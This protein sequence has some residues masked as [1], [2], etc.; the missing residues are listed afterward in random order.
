MKPLFQGILFVAIGLA[1][2]ALIALAS[3]AMGGAGH[4]WISAGIM[5]FSLVTAPLAGLAWALRHRGA[6]R[7][8]AW[9]VLVAAIVIDIALFMATVN[10]GLEYAGDAFRSDPLVLT[11]WWILCFSWQVAAVVLIV[12]T[13]KRAA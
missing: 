2:G 10:E 1:V 4:G 7:I 6:G 9:I 8:I 12:R 3:V 13:G 5:A 11:I